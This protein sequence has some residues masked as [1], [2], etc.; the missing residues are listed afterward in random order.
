MQ[1]AE[2]IE[3]GENKE[4]GEGMGMGGVSR[5]GVPELREQKDR[6]AVQRCLLCSWAQMS[7][8]EPLY[9]TSW[10]VSFSW[11]LDR[12]RED[13]WVMAGLETSP[14]PFTECKGGCVVCQ[15]LSQSASLA[16]EVI[17]VRRIPST[18]CLPT[19]WIALLS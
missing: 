7:C 16:P 17:S 13:T 9:L 3:E 10:G 19:H 8:E 4:R 2:G 6:G 14:A 15:E 11:G 18:P 12:R 5:A 1:A